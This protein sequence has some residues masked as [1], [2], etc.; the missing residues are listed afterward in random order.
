MKNKHF[1]RKLCLIA[2]LAFILGAAMLLA[3]GA[4]TDVYAVTGESKTA[5]PGDIVT[6]SFTFPK[7]CVTRKNSDTSTSP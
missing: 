2:L 3:V 1:T 7:G 6:V 4:E 5:I